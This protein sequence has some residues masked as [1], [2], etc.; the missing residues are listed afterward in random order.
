MAVYNKLLSAA[1]KNNFKKHKAMLQNRPL[2]KFD[3]T[4]KFKKHPKTD[5]RLFFWV[6]ES[7]HV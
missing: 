6:T 4:T 1:K 3:G 5:I 7:P 2:P